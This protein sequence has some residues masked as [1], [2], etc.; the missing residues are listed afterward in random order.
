MAKT[1]LNGINEVL[2]KVRVIQGGGELSSLTDAGRQNHID[3]AV[4]A[5]GEAVDELYSVADVAMPSGQ[6]ES[7]ITLATGTR[8]YALATD[9]VR[10]RWPLIDK[11]NT[12]FIYQYPK[13]YNG[14]LVDDPEQDDTG[15]PHYAA[16]RPT[17]GQLFLDNAPAAADNG[18]VYT[19]QYQKDL[20]LDEASDQ[21]PFSDSVFRAMVPAV[22]ELW[23]RNVRHEIDND[24][25]RLSYGRAARLL[26]RKMPSVSWSPR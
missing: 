25:L 9:L 6:G 17:D 12:Q 8:N 15:L 26:S 7:T 22:A 10:L 13:G 18:K 20:T 21:L 11:T 2:K 16:I 24:I 5:W 1:L 3:N 14:L 4:Q 23:K 19:Y